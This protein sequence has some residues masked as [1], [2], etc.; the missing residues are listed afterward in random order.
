[1]NNDDLYLEQILVGPMEN[2][3]YF[4]R[5]PFAYLKLPFINPLDINV[6]CLTYSKHSPNKRKPVTPWFSLYGLDP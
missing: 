5:T 4:V 2:F 3:V 1:M 6:H